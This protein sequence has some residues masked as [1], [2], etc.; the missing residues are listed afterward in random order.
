MGL[1]LSM[2]CG[3]YI[4]ELTGPASRRLACM[5]ACPAAM[6][7]ALSARRRAAQAASHQRSIHDLSRGIAGHDAPIAN[8]GTLA[9]ISTWSGRSPSKTRQ[10]A[11]SASVSKLSITSPVSSRMTVY[12][13]NSSGR[14]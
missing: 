3:E 2:A 1:T 5:D 8:S 7:P 14:W 10:A 9:R 11:A 4:A 13:G 12:S 6:A